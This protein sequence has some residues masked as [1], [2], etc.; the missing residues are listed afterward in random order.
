MLI[1][2]CF[3]DELILTGWAGCSFCSM[4]NKGSPQVSR[5]KKNTIQVKISGLSLYTSVSKP[6]GA[7]GSL[8]VK[9]KSDMIP[10]IL[11]SS[12]PAAPQINA[13]PLTTHHY[14]ASIS[15][16]PLA[17]TLFCS[18]LPVPSHAAFLRSPLLVH[19]IR[20]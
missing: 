12:W 9:C 15:I 11:A 20:G 18:A 16:L 1:P 17:K 14:A 10:I 4:S 7:C 5:K 3:F 13:E 2:A 19:R 8:Q 6:G